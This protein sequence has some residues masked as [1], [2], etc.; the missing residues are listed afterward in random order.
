MEEPNDSDAYIDVYWRK[1]RDHIHSLPFKQQRGEKRVELHRELILEHN[2][3]AKRMKYDMLHDDSNADISEDV[4][5]QI[6]HEQKYDFEKKITG[7]VLPNCD[8]YVRLKAV[9]DSINLT[10]G[11]DVLNGYIE[12]IRD[13]PFYEMILLSQKQLNCIKSVPE[14]DR[15]LYVDAT[16]GLVKIPKK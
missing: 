10:S 3:S 6:K 1:T 5:R 16:G 14:K 4:I 12:S 8:W 11:N 9:A 13:S 7:Q 2:G 15:I